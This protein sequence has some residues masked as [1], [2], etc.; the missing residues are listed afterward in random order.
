LS[1]SKAPSG[2]DTTLYA[3][4]DL[5]HT[6]VALWSAAGASRREIGKLTAQGF[7]VLV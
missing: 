5:R 3:P 1:R 7:E 2:G 4:H 6:A